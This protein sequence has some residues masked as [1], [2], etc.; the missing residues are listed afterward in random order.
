MNKKEV[1][2]MNNKYIFETDDTR[3]MNLVAN[4]NKMFSVLDDFMEWRRELNRGRAEDVKFLCQ[5]KIYTAEELRK[6]KTL[7]RDENGLLKDCKEIYLVDDV[8]DRI[9]GIIGDLWSFIDRY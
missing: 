1:E 8:I 2:R 7:E 6:D 9:D 5:G 4:R 3:E